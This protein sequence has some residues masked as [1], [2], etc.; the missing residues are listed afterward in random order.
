MNNRM[1]ANIKRRFGSNSELRVDYYVLEP[2]GSVASGPRPDVKASEV[3][4]PMSL[5]ISNGD[6]AFEVR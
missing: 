6:C 1:A 5:A 3:E 2:G 4:N